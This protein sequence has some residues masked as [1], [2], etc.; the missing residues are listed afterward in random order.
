MHPNTVIGAQS[1]LPQGQVKCADHFMREQL[2]LLPG[3]NVYGFGERFGAFVKNGQTINIINQDGGT[4]S[5]QSYKSIPF[6]IAGKPGVA[7]NPGTYYGVFVNESRP[8]SFEVASEVVDRVSFS[9]R[10]ESLEYYV[11]AGDTPK[12]VVGKYNKLTGGSTLPPEWTF[13]LW[14]ST[15]FTT[16]YSEETVMKFVDGMLDRD[17]PLSVFILI[18]SG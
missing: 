6:Y 8:T 10:G 15:S 16:D 1:L 13:G 17:I 5:E 9:V 11:I 3:T 4:G 18:V 12:D 14:L 2:S 7:G